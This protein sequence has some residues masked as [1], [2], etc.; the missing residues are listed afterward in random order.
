M[1]IHNRM[2]SP[3]GISHP[4]T[5]LMYYT[6]LF[7]CIFIFRNPVFIL[8]LFIACC[9]MAIYYAGADSFFKSMKWIALIGVAVLVLNALLVHRG[10]T[11]LFFLFKNP[12]TKEALIYGVYN[13]LML[14]SVMAAFISFNVLL[15]SPKFLYL[16]SGIL[17]KL[18]FV[19]DM[20]LRYI[21][22]FRKRASDLAAI[23]SVNSDREHMTFIQKIKTYGI[24]L[25]ALTAWN[26]EEGME[27]ALSLKVKNYGTHNKVHYAKYRCTLRDIFMSSVF[28][29]FTLFVFIA[30]I[31]G[32]TGFTYYPVTDS[33]NIKDFGI[34]LFITMISVIYLPFITEGIAYVKRGF[35]KL[36]LQKR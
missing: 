33:V 30:A 21:P 24:Y 13:M 31:S 6:A 10:S 9:L 27:T 15:D 35:I 34:V 25:K 18:S 28:V 26:L 1:G 14:M 22:L 4:F 32:H 29:L 12:V 7:S 11:V 2:T 5:L 3:F 16:F 8:F 17:P 36:W 23:R 19:F 20:A